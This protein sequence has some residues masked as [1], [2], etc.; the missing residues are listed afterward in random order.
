MATEKECDDRISLLQQGHCQECGKNV[1]D[2][3]CKIQHH[4]P[5]GIKNRGS[6]FAQ[7][8]PWENLI[9]P[10]RS[11][12]LVEHGVEPRDAVLWDSISHQVQYEV[13]LLGNYLDIDCLLRIGCAYIASFLKGEPLEK[14]RWILDRNS[15]VPAHEQ[16]HAQ[17]P[18]AQTWWCEICER[19]EELGV[20][21]NALY[22][23]GALLLLT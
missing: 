19:C 14:I 22:V 7:G 1:S 23:G 16:A 3:I 12:N 15:S 8:S 6:V 13:I 10:L 11:K 2:G 5:R 9:R 21:R 20:S 18:W 4:F 17:A